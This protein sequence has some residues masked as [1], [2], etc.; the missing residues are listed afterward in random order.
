VLRLR[1]RIQEER[2]FELRALNLEHARREREMSALEAELDGIGA[3][4]DMEQERIFSPIELQW[5]DEYAQSLARRIEQRHRELAVLV[6]RRAA[7]QQELTE[8]ARQVKSLDLLR[9]RAAE[10]FRHEEN[11]VEQK[12][13]DEIGLRKMR[14]RNE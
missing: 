6:E 8:A 7:K 4:V 1:E 3:D 10:N 5:Q 13:L 9:Q 2:E 12:F 14:Q 11:R